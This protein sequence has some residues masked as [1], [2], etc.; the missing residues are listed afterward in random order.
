MRVRQAR[1]S[2]SYSIQRP[3]FHAN[4][5]GTSRKQPRKTVLQSK[6]NGPLFNGPFLMLGAGNEIPSS[7]RECKT[8]GFYYY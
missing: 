2:A 3:A 6:K 1:P 5:D 7:A 8:Q 4:P